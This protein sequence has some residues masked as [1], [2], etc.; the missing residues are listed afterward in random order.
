M[1]DKKKER[2]LDVSSLSSAELDFEHLRKLKPISQKEFELLPAETQERLCALYDQS[3]VIWNDESK[4]RDLSGAEIVDLL[5]PYKTRAFKNFPK[6]LMEDLLT[7][8]A[9]GPQNPKSTELLLWFLNKRDFLDKDLPNEMKDFLDYAYAQNPYDYDM[10]SFATLVGGVKKYLYFD[11]TENQ[12]TFLREALARN[13]DK[14]T[15]EQLFALVDYVKNA[16]KLGV[17]YNKMPESMRNFVLGCYKRCVVRTETSANNR[18]MT[19]AWH[20]NNQD[21]Y[22]CFAAFNRAFVR[23]EN[24]DRAMYFEN[25]TKKLNLPNLINY[26]NM[27]AEYI[28][29]GALFNFGG[30]VYKRANLIAAEFDLPMLYNIYGGAYHFDASALLPYTKVDALWRDEKDGLLIRENND[31]TKTYH[32]ETI[33]DYKERV[34]VPLAKTFDDMVDYYIRV[35]TKD[36]TYDKISSANQE[37]AAN[38][39]ISVFGGEITNHCQAILEHLPTE[40]ELKKEI[41]VEKAK[42]TMDGLMIVDTVRQNLDTKTKAKERWQNDL[43][44]YLRGLSAEELEAWIKSKPSRKEYNVYLSL[45]EH[46]EPSN[47]YP[48]SSCAISEK[49]RYSDLSGIVCIPKKYKELSYAESSDYTDEWLDLEAKL[50]ND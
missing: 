48:K 2:N 9:Q 12:K 43:E 39:L 30:D 4:M 25:P 22:K 24:I 32:I 23:L 38:Y 46:P 17:E 10:D 6:F 13:I 49:S 41:F 27:Q 44:C 36:I 11:L 14:M 5:E 21:Q 29:N 40:H 37:K 7:L 34:L 3:K 19:G 1:A 50:H 8:Y 18:K 20:S 45:F 35:A 26:A 28:G 47:Y 16:T 33:R 15:N 42:E 31:Q